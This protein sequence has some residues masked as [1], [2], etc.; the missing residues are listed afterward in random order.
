LKIARLITTLRCFRDCGYC[1]NKQPIIKQAIKI[2]DLKE[3]KDYEVVC[4]T[5]GEPMLDVTHTLNVIKKLRKQNPNVIVYLYTALMN[6]GTYEVM[7]RVDG[8]HYTLHKGANMNDVMDFERFQWLLP[9]FPGKSFRLYINDQV[10]KPMQIYPSYW[11][12][13]RSEP[14]IENCPLP[15]DEELFI[16]KPYKVHSTS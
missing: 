10:D 12:R 14:W 11:T 13:I 8:I 5:G 2:R 6:S 16:L 3:I 7:K 4:I 15:K 9:E 1:V